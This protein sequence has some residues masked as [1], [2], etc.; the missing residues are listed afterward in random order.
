VT[1]SELS[2]INAAR[3]FATRRELLLASLNSTR[4]LPHFS[5]SVWILPALTRS[6]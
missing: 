2:L 4:Y 6:T 1:R 3:K 5:L